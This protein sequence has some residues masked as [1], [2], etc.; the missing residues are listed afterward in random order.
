MSGVLLN[1]LDIAR[2]LGENPEAAT[3]SSVSHWLGKNYKL[4]KGGGFSYDSSISMLPGLFAGDFSIET[5]KDFCR[6]KGNPIGRKHNCDVVDLVGPY[7]LSQNSKCYK[8]DFSAFV[9]GRFSSKNVYAGVKAPLVRIA[10]ANVFVVLPGFRMGHRPRE[11]E[12]DVACSIILSFLARDDF[13]KAD[14]EY[15]YAG[16]ASSVRRKIRPVRTF[17][18]IHGKDRFLYNRDQVDNLLDVY[19]RG[20]ALAVELGAAFKDANL[21]GYRV[22]DPD[23]PGMI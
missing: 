22:I 7:A 2:S 14:I 20:V 15:L 18:P 16:P 17:F 6:Q 4:N 19:V 13:E 9:I 5:A 10:G 12:I 8:V 11:K 21:R 23:Q 1:V 3:P